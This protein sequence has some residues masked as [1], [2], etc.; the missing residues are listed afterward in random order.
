MSDDEPQIRNYIEAGMLP[1]EFYEIY[2]RVHFEARYRRKGDPEYIP[3]SYMGRYYRAHPDEMQ[4]TKNIYN[5]R[6]HNDAAF[7]AKK[8]AYA[9]E[10]RKKKRLLVNAYQ[11]CYRAKKKG[12]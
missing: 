8:K 4:K 2:F 3:S 1:C 10:Y 9:A 5:N 11:V 12:A 6:Y 7:R